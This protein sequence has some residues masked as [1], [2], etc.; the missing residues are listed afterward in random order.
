MDKE[1]DRIEIIEDEAL[2][3]EALWVMQ[4]ATGDAGERTGP[5]VHRA[6]H[7]LQD[8]TVAE[9]VVEELTTEPESAE[10]M[11][12]AASFADDL[13]A[14]AEEQA[15]IGVARWVA[16]VVAER[17]GD[18]AAAGT[19]LQTAMDAEGLWAPAVDRAAWYASDR[20]DAAYATRLW[21]LLQDTDPADVDVIAPFARPGGGAPKIGRNDPCWC[22]SGRKYKVCHNGEAPTPAL[23]DRV[24]WLA[25]KPVAYLE[26]W[27]AD[28]SQTLWD[29]AEYRAL[30]PDDPNAALVDPIV[31][32]TVLVEAGWFDKFLAARASLLP[33][34]EAE[35]ARSW[36]GIDRT[37]YEVTAAGAAGLTISDLGGG[38]ELTVR[39]PDRPAGARL[40]VRL[41]L[42]PGDHVC[43]RAVPD[44]T[45][46]QFVGAL[47]DVAADEAKTVLDLCTAKDAK[48]LCEL[49][50]DRERAALAE[51]DSST[52]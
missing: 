46:H 16:A 20:G 2:R 19:H 35:L 7:A 27:G 38:A 17:C 45:G 28:A 6:L 31:A 33:A 8:G 34:D 12:V 5:D 39:N 1:K 18:P 41:Q 51:S 37:V 21:R 29:H 4:L 32:D 43:G 48:A 14:G 40:G 50:A 15:H 30:D 36:A 26:R 49:L 42:Q 24:P 22:G 52:A 11:A 25:R 10:R 13:I 44:G 47:F 23:A 3:E 9:Y